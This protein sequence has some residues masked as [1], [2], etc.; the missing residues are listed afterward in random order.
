MQSTNITLSN[1]VKRGRFN[2]YM[3]DFSEIPIPFFSLLSFVQLITI[4]IETNEECDRRGLGTGS[5]YQYMEKVNMIIS[6]FLV[7]SLLVVTS[8]IVHKTI[9]GTLVTVTQLGS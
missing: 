9:K 2:C 6:V 5:R 7:H 3:S 4:I 8:Q 1:K